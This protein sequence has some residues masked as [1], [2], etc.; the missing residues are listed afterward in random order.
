MSSEVSLL[1]FDPR[2]GTMV[3]A[4]WLGGRAVVARAREVLHDPPTAR[5]PGLEVFYASPAEV[6]TIAEASY[7]RGAS[8][9]EVAQLSVRFPSPPHWWSIEHAF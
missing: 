4:R 8:P 1:I 9:D 6:R 2:I 3:R 5:G 7:H